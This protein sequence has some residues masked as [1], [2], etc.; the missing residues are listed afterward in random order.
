MPAIAGVNNINYQAVIKNGNH[1][2]ANQEVTLKFDLYENGEVIYSEEQTKTTTD[3]G[4]VSCLIGEND[5]ISGLNWGNLSLEVSVNLGGGFEV[6][7]R[8]PVSSVPTA[9]Y[10]LRTAE[11]DEIK[12]C[13]R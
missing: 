2:M 4:Y 9:L 11:T 6:I 12:K 8:G 10:A 5:D 7:S 13:S 3:G 1:I